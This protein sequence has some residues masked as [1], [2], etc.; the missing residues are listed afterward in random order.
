MLAIKK[1]IYETMLKFFE[2]DNWRFSKLEGKEVLRMGYSGK[3]TSLLCFAEADEAEQQFLFYSFFEMPAPE[4]KRQEIAE[5]ITRVN[6]GLK[7]GNFEMD[8][9]DGEIRYKCSFT[10]GDGVLTTGMIKAQVDAN[11]QTMDKYAPAIM[12]VLYG[13]V[14]PAR[15][16]A[17]VQG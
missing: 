14:P 12:A 6:Y 4:E 7:L 3:N 9:Y 1:S 15:A 2:E 10:V 5:F 11:V 8:F 17:R 13:D 16:I